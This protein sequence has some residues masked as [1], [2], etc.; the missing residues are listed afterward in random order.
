[1][2]PAHA[3]HFD[4]IR[5]GA[6]NI[7]AHRIQEVCHIHNMRLFIGI[8]NHGLARNADRRQHDIDRSADR[9]L[10]EINPRRMQAILRRN[11]YGAVF[12]LHIAAKSLKSLA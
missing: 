6:G 12:D 1:M 2:Q 7:G 3:A 10:I 8:F 11:V 9:A 5:A 4:H